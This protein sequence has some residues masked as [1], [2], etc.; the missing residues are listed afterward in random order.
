MAKKQYKPRQTKQALPYNRPEGKWT[1]QQAA[2]YLKLSVSSLAKLQTREI[3]LGK[4][5]EGGGGAVYYN[6]ADVIEF[7]KKRKN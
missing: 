2:D 3:L 5:Y 4:Q 7:E 1:R 6:P